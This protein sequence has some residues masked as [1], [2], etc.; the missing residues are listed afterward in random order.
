MSDAL[1]RTGALP[2]GAYHKRGPGWLGTLGLIVSEACIFAYLLFSYYYFDVQLPRS[3][4]PAELPKLHL[5]LPNT[6]I[7][8]L[9]SVAVWWG[10]KGM[11]Q[12]R[13]GQQLLGL[14][15]AIL[16]GLVFVA[17][18]LKE[19]SDRHAL[20]PSSSYASLY[21]TITGFHMAH[22][23][24]GLIAL[25]FLL[26]WSAMGYFDE[27]RGAGLSYGAVYWHFVDAVWLC[28]FFTF[29]ITPRLW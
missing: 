22:V 11:K 5:S 23:L 14:A 28:V 20:L 21:F 18:Q 24:A 13:R 16:L 9:S 25:V 12:G 4:Q 17:V 29:Y 2:V 7:L 1:L 3:W 27:R 15:I 10:E 19:W 6:L 8:L 26:I